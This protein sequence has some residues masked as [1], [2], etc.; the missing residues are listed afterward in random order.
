MATRVALNHKTLGSNPSLRTNPMG[1]VLKVG[2][3]LTVTANGSKL[4]ATVLAVIDRPDGHVQI[5]IETPDG[6]V[7]KLISEEPERGN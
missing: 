2:D 7:Y 4:K 5:T 3:T 6:L 1:K